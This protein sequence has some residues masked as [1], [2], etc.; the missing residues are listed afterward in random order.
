MQGLLGGSLGRSPHTI[1]LE[2]LGS[3]WRG[4]QEASLE[5]LFGGSK[6]SLQGLREGSSWRVSQEVSL[7]DLPEGCR[8]S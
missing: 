6:V 8:V 2:D 7:A 3:P 5:D 1:S 4:S